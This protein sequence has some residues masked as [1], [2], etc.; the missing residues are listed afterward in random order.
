MLLLP[1]ANGVLTINVVKPV[2]DKDAEEPIEI[3]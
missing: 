2:A 1:L 3:K